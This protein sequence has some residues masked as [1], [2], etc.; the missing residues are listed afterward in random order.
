[1]YQSHCCYVNDR[2]RIRK[3]TVYVLSR[4]APFNYFS[5]LFVLEYGIILHLNRLQN[6]TFDLR[7][8]PVLKF[9]EH[10]NETSVSKING[11]CPDL[12]LKQNVCSTE[13]FI[14]QVWICCELYLKQLLIFQTLL[15][16]YIVIWSFLID[17]RLF[18]CSLYRVK[19]SVTRDKYGACTGRSGF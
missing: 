7:H 14:W 10:N 17:E 6:I 16:K 1:M 2:E 4:S 3:D 11:Q 12:F 9:W 18:T 19:H 5:D 13:S 8:E 15:K